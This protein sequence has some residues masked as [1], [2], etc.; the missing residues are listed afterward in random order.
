MGAFSILDLIHKYIESFPI[1]YLCRSFP[2]YIRSDY[3]LSKYIP[4]E[5]PYE[6]VAVPSLAI[7]TKDSRSTNGSD[8]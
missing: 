6:L 2:L 5:S 3:L 8:T 7:Y 4:K 1:I